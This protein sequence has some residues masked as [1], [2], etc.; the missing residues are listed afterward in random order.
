MEFSLDKSHQSFSGV[1]ICLAIAKVPDNYSFE[2][3]IANPLNQIL[4]N[5]KEVT[6]NTSLRVQN[7]KFHTVYNKILKI[8][9]L[10][11][12]YLLEV[13]IISTLIQSTVNTAWNTFTFNT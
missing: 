13:S 2:L 11:T 7:F 8:L 5:V 3:K 1:E 6:K 9:F 12:I 4:M 10:N